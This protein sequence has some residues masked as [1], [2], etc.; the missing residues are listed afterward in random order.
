MVKGTNSVI[1]SNLISTIARNNL[2]QRFSIEHKTNNSKNY[3]LPTHQTNFI[4]TA[5]AYTGS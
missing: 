3:T 5:E 4:D 1:T 2:L